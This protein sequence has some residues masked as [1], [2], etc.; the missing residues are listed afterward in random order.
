MMQLLKAAGEKEAVAFSARAGHLVDAPAGPGVHRR[1][2]VAEVELIGGQLAVR[3]HVPFAQ[4][5]HQLLLGEIGIDPRQRQHVEGQVPG[6]IPGIFPFVGHRDDVPVVEVRPV[7]IA[8]GGALRG[9]RWLLRVAL[10]PIPHD[11]MVKL[12][13]PQQPGVS[14]PRHPALLRGQ[15]FRQALREKLLRLTFAAVKHLI[16]LFAQAEAPEI[17][18]ASR[19]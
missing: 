11:I 3:V 9:R 17:I 8:A 13:A 7:G 10:E 4:E 5:Q 18:R 14:L 16:E 1:I 2:D 19:A 6:G 15:S 12:F